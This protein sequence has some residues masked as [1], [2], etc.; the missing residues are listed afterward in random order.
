MH[1]TRSNNLTPIQRSVVAHG[2]ARSCGSIALLT[3]N[4]RSRLGTS[5]GKRMSKSSLE[6][7]QHPILLFYVNEASRL[8]H[9]KSHSFYLFFKNILLL[10]SIKKEN[11]M[12]SPNQ[13]NDDSHLSGHIELINNS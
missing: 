3:V 1:D 4:L 13:A 10:R 5:N 6:C 12:A 7:F 2:N 9:T 8:V 11:R